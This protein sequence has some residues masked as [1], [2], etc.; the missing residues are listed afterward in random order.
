[1]K[2]SLWIRRWSALWSVGFAIGI[3]LFFGSLALRMWRITVQTEA[4]RSGQAE[5]MLR[6]VGDQLRNHDG[7]LEFERFLPE[8]GVVAYLVYGEALVNVGVTPPPSPLKQDW[9]T[10]ELE[11]CLDRLARPEIVEQFPDT[12]VPNGLFYLARRTLLLAGLHLVDTT[13]RWERTDEY[14]ENCAIMADGFGS[15]RHGLID[16]FPGFC[17]PAD[18]LAALRCLRLHDEKF[19]TA[20]GDAVEKWKQ[21]AEGAADPEHGTLPSLASSLTGEVLSP[22]SGSLLALSLIEL[23]DVD[24]E[25]FRDQYSRFRERFGD[26]FVGL[27]TW[28]E[29]PE[30][31][32]STKEID[33]G[34]IIRGHGVM[35]TLLGMSAAKL[36]GD[37]TTFCNE[38]GL[39]EV[40]GLPSTKSGMRRYLRGRLLILDALC[41]HGLSAVPWTKRAGDIAEV[42]TPPRLPLLFLGALMAFPAF[43]IATT[44]FR[45]RRIVR[46][47]RPLSLWHSESPSTEG[48]V[49]FWC[50]LILLLSILFSI[51]WFPVVWAGF[52]VL[53]RI[54]LFI[55][56]IV[57]E[58]EAS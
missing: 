53:G 14:G 16:S 18:N 21:W 20:Y 26:S 12:Q 41:M 19:E 40:I 50:Q 29:F 11:W 51:L 54:A 13:P 38:M 42:S 43:S 17:L 58:R 34:P 24:G 9:L 31:M 30:G 47:V 2:E 49:L 5:A 6:Y 25:L 35:A 28:R 7:A 3:L 8:A 23:R 48:Q 4:G 45:Y 44:T 55:K 52:G 32:P 56:R 15:S 33:T 10:K 36:A 37:M 27:R 57:K 22:S 46:K 1:M 39:I